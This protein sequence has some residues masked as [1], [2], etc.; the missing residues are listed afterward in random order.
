[1]GGPYGPYRQSERK[2]IY[3]IMLMNW[4]IK[5]LHILVF[6][7]KIVSIL[8]ARNRLTESN[9]HYDGTLPGNFQRTESRKRIAAGEPHVIRFKT[10]QEGTIT[11]Q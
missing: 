1:M 8:F 7:Q 6:A 5:D 11:A 9:L 10:P 4:L 2:E 3:L